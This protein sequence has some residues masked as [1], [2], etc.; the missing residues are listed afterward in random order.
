MKLNLER[1]AF[2]ALGNAYLLYYVDRKEAA[3]HGN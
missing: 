2:M 1:E 3:G